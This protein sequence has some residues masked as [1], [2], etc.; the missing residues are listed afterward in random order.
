MN[1]LHLLVKNNKGER[2]GACLRGGL[3]RGFTVVNLLVRFRLISNWSSDCF[4]ISNLSF[5]LKFLNLTKLTDARARIYR[6]S[7]RLMCLTCW[8]RS[9]LNFQGVVEAKKK[10]LLEF[11]KFLTAKT[12]SKPRWI[13]FK[14]VDWVML[15]ICYIFVLQNMYSMSISSRLSRWNSKNGLL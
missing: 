14:F 11:A 5:L 9:F 1:I 8:L 6:V 7:V 15:M 10:D 4:L 12:P 3:N 2:R 13:L